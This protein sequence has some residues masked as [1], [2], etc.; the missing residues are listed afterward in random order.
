MEQQKLYPL[1]GSL[2]KLFPNLL[3]GVAALGGL[4]CLFAF[5][6]DRHHFYF[7]YLF[8]FLFFLTISLGSLFFVMIQFISAAGWSVVVRRV[9]EHLMNNLWL[10]GLLFI[11]LLFGMPDLFHW[12][13]PDVMEKDALL[14]T[15]SAYLNIPFFIIRAVAFFGIWI[16][17]SSLFFRNS[18]KQDESGDKGITQ[19]LQKWSAPGLILYALSQTYAGFDWIMSLEPHWYSTILGVY[20]F[21]GSVVVAVAMIGLVCHFL[22]WAGFLKDVITVEHYHDLGKLLY[23]FTIFWTYIAFSQFMLI[24]YGNIPEETIW[25]WQRIQGNWKS[26]SILLA[27]GHFAIPFVV[28][29]SRNMRRNLLVHTLMVCW[30]IFIHL[31]DIYWLVMPTGSPAG[32]HPGLAEVCC[33]LVIGG[34]FGRFLLKGLSKFS[35]IPSKDPRL[36]ESLDFENS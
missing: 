1:T 17:L 10:M 33:L 26:V 15:K 11:P 18:V 6:H 28:F 29:M 13:H 25:F 35:L 12:S 32:A 27:V 14:K 2:A 22:R 7:S 36:Q 20:F 19:K 8:A 31:V 4:G 30:M 24:W 21:S 5:F 34:V 16:F 9:A 3:W 23:A